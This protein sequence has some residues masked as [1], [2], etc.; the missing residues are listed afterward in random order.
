MSPI[1]IRALEP[2]RGD[3]RVYVAVV[4]P[5]TAGTVAERC[6]EDRAP[7]ISRLLPCPVWWHGR[8]GLCFEHLKVS[9]GLVVRAARDFLGQEWWPGRLMGLLALACMAGVRITYWILPWSYDIAVE[10]PCE[11]V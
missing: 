6:S 8:V 11:K 4:E 2:V 7:W 1:D 9:W 3:Y 5:V 10:N